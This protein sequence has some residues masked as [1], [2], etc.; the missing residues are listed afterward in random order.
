MT[1]QAFTMRADASATVSYRKPINIGCRGL[2]T[3]LRILLGIKHRNWLART[4]PYLLTA[5]YPLMQLL[6][7]RNHGRGNNTEASHAMHTSCAS[8]YL[9]V[10][11]G[12]LLLTM[13]ARADQPTPAARIY[14]KACLSCHASDGAG[15]FPGVPDLT[16]PSGP[17][18][19]AP[20]DLLVR[21]IT[22]I[23]TPGAAM[24]M[25]P[26]GGDPTLSDAALADVLTYMRKTFIGAAN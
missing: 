9:F 3:E 15:S 6:K 14:A 17:L 2:A 13:P 8:R 1:A 18:S 20:D 21:V 12:T 19:S 4:W 5:F 24:V 16:D 11:I 23:Q 7:H 26:R 22:G 10:L 25:P